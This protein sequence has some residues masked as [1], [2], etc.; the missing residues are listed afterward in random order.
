MIAIAIPVFGQKTSSADVAKRMSG[1][2]TINRDLSSTFGGADGSGRGRSRGGG[3]AHDALFQQRLPAGFRANP[4]NT[5]PTPEGA[6]DLT[7]AA[8]AERTAMRQVE[9]IALTLTITATADR[10]SIED[11]RAEETCAIDGKTDKVRTFGVYMDVRC[12]WEKDRLRQEFSTTRGKLTR[13]W[14]VDD[15]GRLVLKATLE[16]LDRTTPDATAVYDRS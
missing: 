1:T 14:S 16:G 10:V 3:G 2:W 15:N 5:E 11:E 9:E 13:V 8:L 6:G 7:P 12:K 4:T